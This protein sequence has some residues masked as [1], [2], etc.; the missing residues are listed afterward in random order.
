MGKIN[1]K[2]I[3][4]IMLK[5]IKETNI[6]DCK[7]I[8]FDT[9]ADLRGDFKEIYNVKDFSIIN[10]KFTVRQINCSFNYKNAMRGF[11]YQ[12][13]PPQA[14]VMFCT[15][16]AA[17]LV[18]VDM[19]KESPTY[20]QYVN[21]IVSSINGEALFAPGRFAWALLALTDCN[22][23]YYMD[24]L[25]DDQNKM[26]LTWNDSIINIKWPIENKKMIISYE[27]MYCS[28]GFGAI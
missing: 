7:I 4:D 9:R 27:D 16:G 5:K 17:W 28:S 19:R 3:G 8:V 10:Q 20:L 18:A 23:I 26:R 6:P 24:E 15:H 1:G 2:Y 14:R 21:T 12:I 22:V 11:H 13:F 25:Y